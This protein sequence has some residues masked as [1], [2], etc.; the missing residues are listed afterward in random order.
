MP[1]FQCSA[2][3]SKYSDAGNFTSCPQCLGL[4]KPDPKCICRHVRICFG[5]IRVGK[6]LSINTECPVHGKKVDMPVDSTKL[7]DLVGKEA[8]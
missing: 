1:T 7:M 8:E 6:P 3:G 4:G 5:M 2:C